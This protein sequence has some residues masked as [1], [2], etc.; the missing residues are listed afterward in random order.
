MENSFRRFV[1]QE[2]EITIFQHS[3]HLHQ[4]H[5]C[6]KNICENNA[7]LFT[8]GYPDKT[9]PTGITQGGYSYNIV[10]K[11]SFAIRIPNQ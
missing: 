8:Y 5:V 10:A 4:D 11:E 6:N 1:C 3:P 9:S 7:T 2:I